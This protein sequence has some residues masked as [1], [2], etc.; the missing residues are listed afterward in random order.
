MCTTLPFRGGGTAS[1]L[2]WSPFKVA[3]RPI[4]VAL[5]PPTA[6]GRQRDREGATGSWHANSVFRLG[7]GLELPSHSCHGVVTEP[8]HGTN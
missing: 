2:S 7:P 3:L 8:S 1:D 5:E 4:V 6:S